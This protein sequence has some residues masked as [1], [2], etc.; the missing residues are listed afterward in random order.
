MACLLLFV[1]SAAVHAQPSSKAEYLNANHEIISLEDKNDFRLFDQSFY[2]NQI[3]ML[4]EMHGTSNSYR[5]QEVL[6]D[7]LKAKTNFKIYILE[8]D[9]IFAQ[10]ANDYLK[11]G[12]ETVLKNAFEAIKGGFVYSRDY[13]NVFV[14]VRKI[15]QNLKPQDRISFIGVDKVSPTR[16]AFSYFIDFVKRSGYKKNSDA[17]LDALIYKPDDK[18]VYNS[19][20]KMGQDLKSDEKKYRKIFGRNFWEYKFLIENFVASYEINQVRNVKPLSEAEVENVRDAQMAKNFAAFYESLKLQNTKMIGFFGREHTYKAAGKRTNWMTARIKTAHPS[21]KIAALA[22]RYIDSDFMIPTY[23]LEQQFGTKQEKLY[24]FGGF[25]NDTSPFVKA[26]GIEDLNAVEP[27]AGAVL[28]KLNGR[29]SP[30]N[31]LPDLVDEIDAGK[32]TTDYFDYAVLLRRS[33]AA[34]PISEK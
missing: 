27:G 28:F 1:V 15:N 23:F 3:F 10:R 25:Q 13:Y 32:A 33:K 14:N 24:F 21:L 29:N 16:R 34:T 5:M 30:Y 12:D 31:S 8:V 26:V 17:T 9:H 7:L 19:I 20:Q 6:A 22:L 18:Q 4:G 11:S 2:A